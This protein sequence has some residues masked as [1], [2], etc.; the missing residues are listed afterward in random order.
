MVYQNKIFS[1]KIKRQAKNVFLRDVKR[2]VDKLIVTVAI[3]TLSQWLI[4]DIFS[5]H[6]H[7]FVNNSQAILG[8]LY[9]IVIMVSFH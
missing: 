3:F 7:H 6:S 9:K 8:C 4:Y 5:P 2:T 1:F